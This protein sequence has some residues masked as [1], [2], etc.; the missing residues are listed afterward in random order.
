MQ[1]RGKRQGFAVQFGAAEDE[2]RSPESAGGLQACGEAIADHDTRQAGQ[3]TTQD[4]ILPSRQGMADRLIGFTSHNH[5]S[6]DGQTF[7]EMQVFRKVPRQP[8]AQ[9][10]HPIPGHCDND[11]D[12]RVPRLLSHL[13]SVALGCDIESL[14]LLS[15]GVSVDAQN[16]GGLDLVASGLLENNVD[17]R[18]F[19]LVKDH[20]VEVVHFL[21]VYL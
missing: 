3:G 21:Q 12:F 7:E 8:V 17:Q 13:R 19:H 10:N 5:R 14:D 9:A 18:A 1:D 6:A 4:D 2:D 16:L 11:S 20:F 15:Q